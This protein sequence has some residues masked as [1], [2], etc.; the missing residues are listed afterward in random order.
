MAS[1]AVETE[2]NAVMRMTAVVGCNCLAVFNTS[3][4]VLPPIFRS[5]TTTSKK[6]SCSF[7]M[8]ALPFGASSTSCPAS[9]TACA[10]PRR[11]ES[12]S[13][14]MRIRPIVFPLGPAAAGLPTLRLQ[15][16]TFPAGE[17]RQRHANQRPAALSGSQI[18]LSVMRVDDLPYD[19]ESETGP[20]RL[21][22]EERGEHAIRHVRRHPGTVVHQLDSNRL[23]PV[24]AILL[25]HGASSDRHAP[26]P[27]HRFVRVDQQVG[28]QLRELIVIGLNT[29]QRV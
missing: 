20:L 10:S 19:C 8:A 9:A 27:L 14:A 3:S 17:D 1:T 5:L 29:R 18:D 7:S 16:H 12:W 13:S 26:M 4:P 23:A 2:P 11:S 21:G 24:S 28:E 25:L 15:L 6:L 22:R